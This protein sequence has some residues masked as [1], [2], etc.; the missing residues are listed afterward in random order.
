MAG[1]KPG[2]LLQG[3]PHADSWNPKRPPSILQ[4][5][6]PGWKGRGHRHP[7]AFPHMGVNSRATGGLKLSGQVLKEGPKLVVPLGSGPKPLAIH[8]RRLQL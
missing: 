1:G 4:E 7:Q 6:G 5:P 2:E 8:A 3:D